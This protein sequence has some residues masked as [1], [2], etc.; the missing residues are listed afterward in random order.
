MR[1][2]I[3]HQLNI[4]PPY[5]DLYFDKQVFNDK[6]IHPKHCSAKLLNKVPQCTHFFKK[7]VQIYP[8]GIYLFIIQLIEIFPVIMENEMRRN[9][10]SS[11]F[12]IIVGCI[13]K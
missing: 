9:C 2:Y 3:N 11:N 12:K 6:M 13:M 1:P 8:Y 7:C 4:H 10:G 5:N